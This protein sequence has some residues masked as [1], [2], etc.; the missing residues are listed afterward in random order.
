MIIINEKFKLRPDGNGRYD[1]VETNV[2]KDPESENFGNTY[3]N[4]IGYSVGLDTAL[5]K[6]IHIIGSSIA[7]EKDISLDEYIKILSST[8]VRI[9]K[10]LIAKTKEK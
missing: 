7:D 8:S 5:N 3:E 4:V 6:L 10:I 2:V 9:N 1:I